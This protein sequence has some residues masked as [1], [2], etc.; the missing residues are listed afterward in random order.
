MATPKR[1]A[2]I[3]ERI[4]RASTIKNPMVASPKNTAKNPPSHPP[5]TGPEMLL[6]VS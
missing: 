1:Q 4:L 2:Q 5:S 3:I 6:M